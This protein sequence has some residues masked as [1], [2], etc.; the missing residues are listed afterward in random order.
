MQDALNRLN[1]QMDGR[2]LPA[3][4]MGVGINCGPVVVGNIGSETR[5][6]YG[7]VGASVNIT[8]RIQGQSG[9]GE[10]VIAGPVYD[11]INADIAVKRTFSRSLK[12]VASPV[13]LYTVVPQK[14]G[15][16]QS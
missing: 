10:V 12:G 1:R 13:Q 7:I 11:L 16:I 4:E 5:K 8:Q 6:K 14:S 2:G 9:A 3:I 15:N